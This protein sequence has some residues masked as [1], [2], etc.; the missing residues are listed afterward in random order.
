MMPTKGTGMAKT[1][2]L[3]GAI[4][5]TFLVLSCCTT[6]LIAGETE[7]Q[8]VS[9]TEAVQGTL[10]I[11]GGGVRYDNRDVWGRFVA[12]AA[13]YA[14]R[15]AA[16]E[17]VHPRI[18]VFP[19]ASAYP[20]STGE[21]LV[22]NLRRYGADAFLVPVAV[23]N[24]SRDYREAVIDPEVVAAVR[25]SHGVF[26]SGGAQSRILQALKHED[27]SDTPVLAAIRDVYRHG[28]AVG[29]TSAGAAIWSRIICRDVPRQL[30]VLR[31]GVEMGKEVCAGFGFLPEDWFVDQ[32][33]IARGR[34]ARALVIMH[35]QGFRWGLGVDEDTAVVI[36]GSTAEVAGYGGVLLLDLDQAESDPAQTAFNLRNVRLAYFERGD[37]LDL[38]TRQVS[39]AQEKEEDAEL[40]EPLAADD[41]DDDG[42]FLNDILAGS[43]L[44]TAMK[45]LLNSRRPEAFGLAFDGKQAKQAPTTGFEFR[46]YRGEGTKAWS[47]STF[48]DE[49]LT[50]TNVYMDVRPVE[51][52]QFSI[53]ALTQ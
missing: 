18:A 51:I 1:P 8:V 10:L 53:E 16:T 36:R 23:R 17:G 22:A 7:P 13:E 44:V 40:I 27:E 2:V 50:I 37:R 14:A 32:H 47:A 3:R 24:Y 41:D 35:S 42:L 9:A 43:T 46:L 19:T 5:L 4:P 33:F 21:R 20:E 28:G 15:D 30:P 26:F 31:H 52:K 39:L 38:D 6:H 34:F 48:G 12:L 45:G 49:D 25:N 29:G 11:A